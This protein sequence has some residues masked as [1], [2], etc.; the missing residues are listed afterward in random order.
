MFGERLTAVLRVRRFFEMPVVFLRV[1]AAELERQALSAIAGQLSAALGYP[2]VAPETIGRD[3]LSGAAS[4]MGSLSEEDELLA[5]TVR[6]G[7]ARLALAVGAAKA[8]AGAPRR[9]IGVALDGVELVLRE[10]LVRGDGTRLAALMPS[11]VFL[12]TVP[13]VDQDEAI[14]LSRRAS[15]LMERKLSDLERS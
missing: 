13:I 15:A 4:S 14:E 8:P 2:D 6:A 9:A 3:T 11:F 1:A 5:A 12:V 10:E 7:L